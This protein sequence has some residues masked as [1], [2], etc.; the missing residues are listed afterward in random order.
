MPYSRPSS[1]YSNTIKLSYLAI[2]C[3]SLAWVYSR[4]LQFIASSQK[5]TTVV[6]CVH[7]KPGCH[8]VLLIPS[9]IIGGCIQG[10]VILSSSLSLSPSLSPTH[11]GPI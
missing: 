3:C 4:V 6:D 2:E 1:Y 7:G 11:T 9:Y 8:K 5:M 10:N